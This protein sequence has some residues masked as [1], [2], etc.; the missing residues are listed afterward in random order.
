MTA[1]A[2]GWCDRTAARM[3]IVPPH[4]T[5]PQGQDGT[6]DAAGVTLTLQNSKS[7]MEGREVHEL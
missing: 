1:A 2:A 4:C 5:L 7:D 3:R 6:P